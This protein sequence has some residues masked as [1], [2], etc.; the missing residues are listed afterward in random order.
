MRSTY[1]WLIGMALFISS[2]A[3][4]AQTST[5]GPGPV[6]PDGSPAVNV[7]PYQN[8][9]N[10]TP[11]PNT[12]FQPPPGAC[13]GDIV[14]VNQEMMDAYQAFT[15]AQKGGAS[16][17][18]VQQEYNRYMQARARLDCLRAAGR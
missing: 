17:D 4:M 2:S 16:P 12:N 8:L 1:G 15:N 7:D 9:R 11:P 5:S 14:Q 18:A 13:S 6:T 10:Y 3:L